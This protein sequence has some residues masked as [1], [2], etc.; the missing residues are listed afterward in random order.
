MIK[1]LIV[2]DSPLMRRLLAQV[3]TEDGGFVIAQA[4]DGVEALERLSDFAPD[5]VTLDV[6]MPGLDGLQT[7]D[8]I[9]L[10]RPCPVVMVSALTTGGAEVTLEALDLGAVDFVAKPDGAVTL[11]METFAPALV[12]TVREAASAR[13]RRTHRL[14]ERVRLRSGG[15]PTVL[16]TSAATRRARASAGAEGEPAGLVVVGSSTGGPPALDALLEPLGADFPW[17]I[18]VA[19]HMPA[20]FTGS[21][22][23]RLDR[24]CALTVVEVG[25]PMR[26]SAG[27][28]YVARGDADMILSRRAKGLVALPA[29]ES[30]RHRW[31]PS[32]DRLMDSAMAVLPS[33]RLAGVLLTGMGDD[34]ARAMAALRA[35]GGW[36]LAESERSAVVWG[37]PGELVKRGGASVVADVSDAAARLVEAVSAAALA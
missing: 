23:Q 11:K 34:G 8:Q 26:L 6:N 9:M 28:V 31:H 30:D 15:L 14:A 2:D 32:V 29:P 25:Q 4:R 22:A 36:T 3:F 7:L 13:V 1:L 5:V 17:P 19:Q 20:T 37:M 21:L 10:R 35:D 18:V 12:A 33:T 16:P 27:T 24:L